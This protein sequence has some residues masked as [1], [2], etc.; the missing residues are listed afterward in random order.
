MD[1]VRKT[2]QNVLK[3][4][5]EQFQNLMDYSNQRQLVLKNKEKEAVFRLPM[6]LALVIGLIALIMKQLLFLLVIAVVVALFMRYSFEI[7][8]NVS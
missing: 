2:L 7:V 4:I 6:T 3:I 8:R 1:E 5:V